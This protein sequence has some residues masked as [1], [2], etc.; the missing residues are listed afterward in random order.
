M[1]GTTIKVGR[2]YTVHNPHCGID[3]N[4]KQYCVFL[5]YADENMPIRVWAKDGTPF[6]DGDRIKITAIYHVRRY[7]FHTNT[8]KWLHYVEVKADAT[9]VG[10]KNRSK[11]DDLANYV[12]PEI[13]EGNFDDDDDELDDFMKY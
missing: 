9:I 12:P 10:K 3:K 4:G 1:A 5:V 2:S 11:I 8:D 7:Q 13:V 6:K